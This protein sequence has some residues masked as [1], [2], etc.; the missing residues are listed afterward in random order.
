MKND[1]TNHRP[2]IYTESNTLQASS[3]EELSRSYA[4]EM[5][6][7]IASG[8]P[9]KAATARMMKAVIPAFMHELQTCLDTAE[10]ANDAGIVQTAVCNLCANII[11][12][13]GDYIECDGN[14]HIALMESMQRMVETSLASREALSKPEGSA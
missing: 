5:D 11:I 4:A 9:K 10:Q 7:M 8:N 1:I 14:I 13:T 12:N 3:P 2:Q 6:K